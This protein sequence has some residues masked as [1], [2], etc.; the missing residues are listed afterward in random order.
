VF[1]RV[2]VLGAELQHLA[3]EVDSRAVV[4]AEAA[5]LV[6]R[7][8]VIARVATSAMTVLAANGAEAA[9]WR[10][11]HNDAAA[12]LSEQSGLGYYDA[13]R[14][15]DASQR[16]ARDPGNVQADMCTGAISALKAAEI[17]AGR[18][19]AADF[20]RRW[21]KRQQE[22]R[23]ER[24]R[25]RADEDEA[26]AEAGD[27]GLF[28]E[29]EAAPDPEP[30][31]DEVD[32]EPPGKT[33]EEVEEELRRLAREGDLSALRREQERLRAAAIDAHERAQRQHKGRSWNE[34]KFPDGSGGGQYK[35]PCDADAEISAK[36]RDEAE[37]LLREA[38][39]RGDTTTT[40]ANC[41]ADAH[42][43]FFG[44]TIQPPPD[45]PDLPPEQGDCGAADDATG[46]PAAQPPT[47]A[48]DAAPPDVPAD[49]AAPTGDEPDHTAAPGAAPG[50]A[51]TLWPDEPSET[52]SD[53]ADPA[54]VTP[55]PGDTPS[56][57]TSARRKRRR[58]GRRRSRITLRVDLEALARGVVAPGERCELHGKAP[59]TVATAL[60]LPGDADLYLAIHDGTR[61]HHVTH[62]GRRRP[63]GTHLA[64]HPLTATRAGPDVTAVAR[65]HVKS[66]RR[67]LPGPATD[68]AGVGPVDTATLT[69]LL[70]PLAALAEAKGIAVQ[71]VV[72]DTRAFPPEVRV[73][74]LEEHPSCVDCGS[75]YSLEDDHD[76]P[77][78][79]G[80]RTTLAN[81][82]PRCRGDHRAKTK[83]EASRT[84][85]AG[86]ARAR[87]TGRAD[88]P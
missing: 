20:Q 9:S 30:D 13:K 32:E 16:L 76:H 69:R 49:A 42:A 41:L 47:E 21:R 60:R 8:G 4:P 36:I 1:D 29:P 71:E 14:L 70:G 65:V 61:V 38:R 56:T 37:R 23:E 15:L 79:L 80:G 33:P 18:D 31:V 77:H 51:P 52:D 62:L 66:L 11:R 67:L 43:G 24:A 2:V 25:R 82:R 48:D 54:S 64:G 68:L 75:P 73:A 19:A 46:R 40:Y 85:R 6:E 50:S 84:V 3:A 87:A 86:Q 63:P 39:R 55:P 35:I 5:A 27:G 45:R 78:A 81:Y 57:P 88:P 83:R 34:K 59:V 28:P 26:A 58:R 44:V 72:F 74:A 22:E 12:W 53:A 17:L 7:F 10:S